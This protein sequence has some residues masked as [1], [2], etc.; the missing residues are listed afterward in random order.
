M[1]L[2]QNQVNQDRVYSVAWRSLDVQRGL[3][4]SGR[5]PSA[6]GSDGRSAVHHRDGQRTYPA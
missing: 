6:A 5:G 1:Y 3:P 4:A 2:F